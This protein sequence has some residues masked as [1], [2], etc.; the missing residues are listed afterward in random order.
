MYD[1]VRKVW[2]REGLD[3]KLKGKV[4]MTGWIARNTFY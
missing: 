1:E 4:R 3:K 2:L